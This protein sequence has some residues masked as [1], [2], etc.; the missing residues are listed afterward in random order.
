MGNIYNPS[1]TSLLLSTVDR[2]TA[3][4]AAGGMATS[5]AH[6]IALGENAGI[7]LGAA[8][9]DIILLGEL[10]GQNLP[11]NSVA[12][13]S[14]GKGAAQNMTGVP[15]GVV[16]IGENA[17]S[18]GASATAANGTVAIGKNALA[19]FV[20]DRPAAPWNKGNVAIGNNV[21]PLWNYGT[22]NVAIGQDIATSFP[23]N[24]TGGAAHA[25]MVMI[26]NAIMTNIIAGVD[27]LFRESIF[28]GY[29]VFG[30]TTPSGG[31]MA[32][33]STVAIGY[34]VLAEPPNNFVS[35]TSVYIGF[36]AGMNPIVTAGQGD[37]TAVGANSNQNSSAKA[38]VL[39]GNG[40]RAAFGQN[41]VVVGNGNVTGGTGR[42]TILG[43]GSAV[44]QPVDYST[45][46]GS[47]LGTVSVAATGIIAIGAGAASAPVI[48]ASHIIVLETN[49]AGTKRAALYGSLATG[50][51]I[52]CNSPAADRDLASMGT[53]CVKL[54][55]GTVG[56]VAPANGGYFYVSAGALHWVGSAGT[57]TVVA[58]A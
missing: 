57:D 25:N 32:A 37:I 45:M 33:S 21:M 38:S 36:R 22:A 27:N 51:L 40:A 42:N 13:V 16:A 30:R 11:A 7:N 18:A 49:I 34:E 39:I 5:A 31:Q 19:A 9:T 2:L 53:N 3:K 23:G 15:D 55:N 28:I 48:G 6:V 52:L 12:I 56:G 54:P 10:A 26:G 47:D 24:T 20:Q 43:Y 46:V 17:L 1:P 14:I 41:S 4:N 44:A 35:G 29:R 8:S 50:N 58:P